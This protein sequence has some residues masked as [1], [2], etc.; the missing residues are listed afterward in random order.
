MA[1]LLGGKAY[2]AISTGV[3]KVLADPNNPAAWPWA[4]GKQL[5]IDLNCKYK[6]IDIV[7]DVEKKLKKLV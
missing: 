1:G 2:I 4:I 3:D 6:T 7:A 5:L